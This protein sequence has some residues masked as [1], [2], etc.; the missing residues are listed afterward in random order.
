MDLQTDLGK[1]LDPF[2]DSLS[3]LTYFFCYAL[4]GIMPVWIFI[5]ILYRDLSVAFIRQYASKEGIVMGSRLSGKLKAWIYA[6]GGA[7]GLVWMSFNGQTLGVV[8]IVATVVF[9]LCGLVAIWS[10]GDYASTLRKPR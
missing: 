8:R 1:I 9:G 4:A 6:F 10:F 7:A 2:A 3:R 5:L